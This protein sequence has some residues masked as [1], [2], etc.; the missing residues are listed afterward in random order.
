MKVE[1]YARECLAAIEEGDTF[2]MMN[3]ALRK[4]IRHTPLNV[5]A[6]K[7]EAAD[8]LIEAEKFVV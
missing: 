5:I 1:Q 4:L 3:S 7:R 2:R 8:R 6:K